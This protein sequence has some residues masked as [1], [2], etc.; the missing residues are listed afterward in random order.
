MNKAKGYL[1]EFLTLA[2]TNLLR[3]FEKKIRKKKYGENGSKVSDSDYV[4]CNSTC[5]DYQRESRVLYTSVIVIMI[6][7]TT[8]IYVMSNTMQI[9]TTK[10]ST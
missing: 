6:I 4:P 3:N 9:A 8:L 1:L 2:T 5:N 7:I 10:I